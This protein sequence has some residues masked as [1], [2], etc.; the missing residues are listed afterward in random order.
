MQLASGDIISGQSALVVRQMLRSFSHGWYGTINSNYFHDLGISFIETQ[1][2]ILTLLE[3]GYLQKGSQDPFI[4]GEDFESFPFGLTTTDEGRRIAVTRFGKRMKRKAIENLVSTVILRAEKTTELGCFTHEVSKMYVFG[5]YL[6][7]DKSDYGD[8]DL[9]CE[10]REKN[11]FHGSDPVKYST[12]QLL[13]MFSR[14]EESRG[15]A[16]KQINERIE[17]WQL[18]YEKGSIDCGPPKPHQYASVLWDTTTVTHM[19]KRKNHRISLHS[20]TEFEHL[21]TDQIRLIYDIDQGGS[22]VSKS[23]R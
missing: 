1:E 5:S 23:Y 21:N 12:N 4:C 13:D 19:L 2:L 6:D 18:L 7:E 11:V 20:V 16:V 17:E 15:V 8:L 14:N 9:V 3:D 22:L 10:E